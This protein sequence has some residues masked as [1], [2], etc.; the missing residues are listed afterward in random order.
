MNRVVCLDICQPDVSVPWGD[1]VGKSFNMIH[2]CG[3]D[4]DDKS[5]EFL[6][7]S[8]M[9]S[10]WMSSQEKRRKKRSAALDNSID[11]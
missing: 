10:L 2:T 4:R 3:Y 5:I 1:Q 6:G 9:F 11:Y 8:L 7:N